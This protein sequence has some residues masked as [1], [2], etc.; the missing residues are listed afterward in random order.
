MKCA[1]C[2]SRKLKSVLS[3]PKVHIVCEH[4]GFLE[5]EKHI[6]PGAGGLVLTLRLLFKALERGH[7][8]DI[9]EISQLILIEVVYIFHLF[10]SSIFRLLGF[11][12]YKSLAHT[13]AIMCVILL[14]TIPSVVAIALGYDLV[15]LA[16]GLFG[17]F[18]GITHTLH[19][20]GTYL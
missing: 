11:R 9:S 19:S 16:L 20:V 1:G 3:G 10:F 12:N 13:P 5:E 2:S 14:W 7:F 15:A 17:L 18:Y 4:C 8:E 6:T